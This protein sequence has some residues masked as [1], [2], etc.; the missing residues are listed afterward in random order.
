LALKAFS[1]K[2]IDWYKT[3]QRDLPWRH[4]KNAYFIWLS[5]IILQQTRVAQGLPYY[6]RFIETYPTVF[7]LANAPQQEVLR[8]WQ[9]LGYYSRARNLYQTA[10]YVALELDGQF[11]K[12][13]KELLKLKGI[14]SYTAAAI[15]SFAYGEP[16]AV[17]DGNVFRV[18][19]RIFGIETDILSNDGK[20][21]F[22]ELANLL[23]DKTRP[24][25]FNQAMM[26]FGAVQCTPTSPNCMMCPFQND[27]L[28]Y[29]TNRIGQLPVKAKKAK[30]KERFFN[31]LVFRHKNK[32]A[33]SQRT[34]QDIWQ[35]LYEFC[36]IESETEL[37]LSIDEIL[38][39][40]EIPANSTIKPPTQ[41][42]T[43]ILTHQRI[44]AQF[45]EIE[46]SKNTNLPTGLDFY[47][48]AE[49]DALP[50]PVLV[51]NYWK[52]VEK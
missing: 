8:L 46:L 27:C 41:I 38:Q 33:M 25:E 16:V 10:R 1:Y 35:Q 20:K 29:L 39:L 7:D 47:D 45:W 31:Y 44:K 26:E 52:T 13:Y 3:Y 23:L 5:E 37:V 36:L 40:Y 34:A 32:V 50:K 30:T 19:S 9:G 18:L 42:F 24:S 49:F 21:Q 6:Q 12:S 11:P 14:G 51:T 15:A 17:L 48:T 28:A 2:I 4:T 22:F 43:H